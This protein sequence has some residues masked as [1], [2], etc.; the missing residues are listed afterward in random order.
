MLPFYQRITNQ[1]AAI[2]I[3][4]VHIHSGNLAVFVSSVVINPFIRITAGAV[5]GNLILAVSQIYA[6]P[7]LC[8]RAQ[9]MEKLADALRFRI[10][11][12]RIHFGKDCLHKTGSGGQISR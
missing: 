11:G 10:P 3:L 12:Y 9:N 5:N 2:Q 7:L 4:V 6:A 1:F 8:H